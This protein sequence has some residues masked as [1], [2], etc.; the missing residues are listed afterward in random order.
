MIR[1][2]YCRL[3]SPDCDVNAFSGGIFC[4]VFVAAVAVAALVATSAPAVAEDGGGTLRPPKI[5]LTSVAGRQRAVQ[6]SYCVQRTS[7]D[8]TM[9]SGCADT[10]ELG[11]RQLSVVR[12]GETVTIRLRGATV[13]EGIA[14]VHPLGRTGKTV[15]RFRLKGPQT[16]WRIRLRPRAYEID[17]EVARFETSD[18]RRGDTSGTVGILVARGGKRVVVPVVEGNARSAR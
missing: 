8:G 11:P 18:L 17:V 12:P 2:C 9:V 13:V 6:E 15:L 5:V 16:R 7:E 10:V 3:R 14:T 1:R 4:G